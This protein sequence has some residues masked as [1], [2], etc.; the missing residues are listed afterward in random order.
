MTVEHFTVCVSDSIARCV[1]ATGSFPIA[2]AI[3]PD[4]VAPYRSL[5]ASEM[6]ESVL[7]LPVRLMQGSGVAAI[8]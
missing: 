4:A 8:R 6:I 7:P 3:G 5:C 2:L 1:A